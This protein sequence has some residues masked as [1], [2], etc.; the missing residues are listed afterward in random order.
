LIE[1]RKAVEADP[2]LTVKDRLTQSGVWYRIRPEMIRNG[3]RPRNRSTDSKGRTIYDWGSTRKGLTS[4]IRKTI[5]EL[6]P[7]EDITREYLV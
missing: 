2:S 3:F 5:E 7:E 4:R 1:R 6:W